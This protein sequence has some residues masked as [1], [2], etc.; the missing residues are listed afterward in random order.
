MT[1]TDESGVDVLAGQGA[2]LGN[3]VASNVCPGVPLKDG[4]TT[5]VASQQV[6]GS[7]TLAVANAGNGKAGT[8]VLYLR[9]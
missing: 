9:A 5:G 1:L 6:F 2:N 3:A 7:L 8:V 4:T